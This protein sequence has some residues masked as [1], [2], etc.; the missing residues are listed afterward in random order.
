MYKQLFLSSHKGCSI[1]QINKVVATQ[2][3]QHVADA[4]YE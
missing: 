2:G 3:R 4:A 1:N